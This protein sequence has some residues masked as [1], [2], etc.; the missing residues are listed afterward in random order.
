MDNVQCDGSEYHL[1]NCAHRGW[2]LHN[3]DHTEDAGVACNPERDADIRLV[4]GST[5]R[6]G[7]VEV[8]RYGQWETVCDDRWDDANAAVVCRQLGYS[9][10]GA[11]ALPQATL[12][13]GIG[14]I[15]SQNIECTGI[16]TRLQ[17]CTRTNLR[18][19][20]NHGVRVRCFLEGEFP[21]L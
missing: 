3:C 16:E 7:R 5:S 6:E 1:Q 15:W 10:Q 21:V 12:G 4:G 2:G 18:R 17:D 13:E 11:T 14:S 19:V 8:D 20:C 9:T